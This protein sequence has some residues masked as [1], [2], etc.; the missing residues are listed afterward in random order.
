MVLLVSYSRCD[1]GH[2][3]EY[4][5]L[6]V[7]D[8]PNMQN[9][10]QYTYDQLNVVQDQHPVLLTEPPLNPRTNRGKAAEIFFEHFNVPAFVVQVQAILSLYVGEC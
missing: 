1:I 9:I 2:I 8:W 7:V 3:R 10:W 4:L 5:I 6:C